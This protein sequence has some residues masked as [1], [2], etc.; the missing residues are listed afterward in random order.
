MKNMSEVENKEENKMSEGT[1]GKVYELGY[2]LVPTIAE[3]EVASVYGGLKDLISGF[4]GS[5]VADEMPRMM[6]I[7]YSMTKVVANVR[8][9]F[10]TAYFGWV[11]FIMLPADVLELKRKLD[12]DP[13]V[14]RFLL[15]KTVKENTMATKRF[16]R[17]DVARKAPVNKEGEEGATLP[18]DKAEIDKEIDAMVSA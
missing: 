16:P 11:K 5:F 14:I 9:K 4:G 2:L 17:A 6:P 3:E 10:N 1:D 15:I 7:A 13:N 8:S 12:F 18:I